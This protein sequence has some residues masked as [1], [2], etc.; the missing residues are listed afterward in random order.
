MAKLARLSVDDQDI[1][2]LAKEMGAIIDFMSA[3]SQWE[4]E[5]RPEIPS[6]S[7]R[8]DI[9]TEPQGPEIVEAAAD[10]EQGH[11]VVPPIKGA[12]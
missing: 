8:P 9:V 6:T 10:Y 4:G 7:R 11:V 1:N 3:I 5:A 2:A 12:S